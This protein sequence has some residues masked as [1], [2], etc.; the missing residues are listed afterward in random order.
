MP[1]YARRAQVNSQT[2]LHTNTQSA[3]FVCLYT[4]NIL[5]GVTAVCHVL[6]ACWSRHVLQR[7]LELAFLNHLWLPHCKH[8]AD[9]GAFSSCVTDGMLRTEA[10]LQKQESPPRH[11]CWVLLTKLLEVG[12]ASF[13]TCLEVFPAS[14]SSGRGLQVGVPSS[15]AA[16]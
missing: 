9:R 5:I 14:T 3:E 4:V 1:H 6:Q 12:V 10:W 15:L 11:A 2:S 13:L 16:A 8:A 7:R